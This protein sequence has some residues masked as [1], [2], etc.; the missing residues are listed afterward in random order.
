VASAGADA[1]IR[2]W[3]PLIGQQIGQPLTGHT[4]QVRALACVTAA[5]GRAL[6]VSGGHDGTVRLWNPATGQHL[7][8]IPLA[9]PVHAL[10]QQPPNQPSRERTGNGATVTVGLRTGVLALDLHLSLF[11]GPPP[12]ARDLNSCAPLGD[13]SLWW[14]SGV[15]AATAAR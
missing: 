13:T 3:D 6:L 2:L 5:G 10:L 1:T 12:T 11:P 9:A 7:R 14:W 15:N 8:A 4:D